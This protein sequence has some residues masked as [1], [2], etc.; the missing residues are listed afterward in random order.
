[1]IDKSIEGKG[2]GCKFEFCE[3][4]VRESGDWLIWM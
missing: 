3:S 2:I 4:S 1:M